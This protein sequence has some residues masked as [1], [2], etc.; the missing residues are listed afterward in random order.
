[1]YTVN[2]KYLK[3]NI[4]QTYDD[5]IRENMKY[6]YIFIHNPKTGGE[7]IETL[8]NIKKNHQNVY[9]RKQEI[10][11]KYSFTFVRHPVSRIVSWYNHLRKHLY[12]KDIENNKLNNNSQCYKR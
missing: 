2:G 9:L 4:I 12:F 8:L 1:M 7:T 5:N 10:E 11:D 3:R 6:N